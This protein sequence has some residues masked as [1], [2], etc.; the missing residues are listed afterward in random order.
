MKALAFG[1]IRVY[2]S[3]ILTTI[4]LTYDLRRYRKGHMT[5]GGKSLKTVTFLKCGFRW[6]K[7]K[8]I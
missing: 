3:N 7:I 5:L 1:L 4:T 6:L 2:F 8:N